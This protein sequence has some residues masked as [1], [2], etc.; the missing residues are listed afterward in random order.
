MFGRQD[1]FTMIEVLVVVSIVGTLAAV[2][3]PGFTSQR[4]RAQ[5]AVAKDS[6]RLAAVTL[7][8]WAT[9]TLTFNATKADLIETEPELRNAR[10][11]TISGTDSTYRITV[12]S[13]PGPNGG[14][15]A[16]ARANDGSLKRTCSNRGAGACRSAPDAAGNWW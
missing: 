8:T 1:G 14:T 15:F 9:E 6:V 16:I 4:G 7:Q 10:N 12:D 3:I 2:A 11:L 5:D 13:V